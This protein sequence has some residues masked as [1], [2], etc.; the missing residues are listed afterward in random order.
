VA[1]I[2]YPPLAYI[3]PQLLRG[4]GGR[5]SDIWAL[6]ATVQQVLTG[7][8]PFPGIEELPVV[9]ALAQLLT[10]PTPARAE[11]PSS[12]AALVSACLAVDPADRPATAAEVADRLDEAAAGL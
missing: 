8:V 4:A 3:D 6:G 9:Q 10:A 12:V 1:Q 7:Q 5:W 2:G 11:L